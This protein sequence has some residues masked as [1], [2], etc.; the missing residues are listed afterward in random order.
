MNILHVCSNYYPAFGGPQYTLKHLSEKLVELYGDKVEV[1]TSNSWY[2]PEMN[3][4]KK[5]N[6]SAE[7]IGGVSINRFPFRR[8]HYPLLTFGNKVSGKLRG[9]ALPYT[10][11]KH[12]WAM[13]CR[14]I[15]GRMKYSPA[16]VI[17][18]TTVH[19]NFS[20]YPTWRFI[21][22]NPKPFVLYGALHLNIQLTEQSPFIQ[23]AKSCDCYIANTY[24]EEKALLSY[25]VQP[26]K[27]VT[28]G[29]GIDTNDLEA[30]PADIAAFK[31][32][33]GIRDHEILIGHVGRL[34]KNKG[35]ELLLKAF[36]LAYQKNKRI[37]LLLAGSVTE[38]V[39][40]LKQYIEQEQLPVTLLE[41]FDEQ[42]KPVIFNALDIFVLASRGESFGVVF[43][44]AWAC[45]KPVIGAGTGA[46]ASLISEGK[47]GYLFETENPESL[48][49]KLQALVE[50]KE[51][52]I[53]FGQNG[54]EKV[55][56]N[57]TWPVIVAKYREAYQRGIHNFREQYC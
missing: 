3:I 52:R 19:Y 33:Y 15:D 5:I 24:Y 51:L 32:K 54:Y 26:H 23:R 48:A 49:E 29:T 57:F 14:G 46:I 56:Q 42:L 8:W 50:H 20:D 2:G 7:M 22:A 25:G 30:K 47:D 10:I 35:A 13:D 53:E 38:Y 16:D 44:E 11:M 43:L 6:P 28:I 40:E 34:S 37:R 45:R 12:R 1:A 31:K 9:K 41:D 4:F 17:M 55:N 27:I 21:T 36:R 39:S 18:A